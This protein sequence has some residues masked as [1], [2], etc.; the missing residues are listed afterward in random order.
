MCRLIEVYDMTRYL[1]DGITLETCGNNK[2]F[3]KA[4]N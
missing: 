1:F 4:V 3:G 2:L